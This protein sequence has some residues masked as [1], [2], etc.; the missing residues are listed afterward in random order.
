[1]RNGDE[2]GTD[3]MDEMRTDLFSVLYS[4]SLTFIAGR[5]CSH[6]GGVIQVVR[7]IV[8]VLRERQR[9]RI[10]FSDKGLSSPEIGLHLFHPNALIPPYGG[11][12]AL[13][14]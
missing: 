5:P 9:G 12:Y 7:V 2:M 1:M 14:H 3:E 13:G 4:D 10:Y 6:R 8:G 11:V